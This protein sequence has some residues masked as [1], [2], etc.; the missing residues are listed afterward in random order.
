MTSKPKPKSN[1]VALPLENRD[2]Q[3]SQV[4]YLF[5]AMR[6]HHWI[7]NL[8]VFTG[9]LFAFQLSTNTFY[10]TLGAFLCFCLAASAIYLLNDVL[11][12]KA[13]QAHPVKRKRPIAAGFVSV[14]AALRMAAFCLLLSLG[15]SFWI[16]PWLG[17]VLVSYSVLQ[18]L[19]NTHLKHQVILDLMCISAGFVLRGLAGTVAA[20]VLPSSWFI[21]CVGL[22]ALYLAIEKRKAEIKTVEAPG[23][24][25]A[26]LQYYSLTWLGRME[27]IVTASSVMAYCLWTIEGAKTPWMMLTIPFVIYAIFKYQ[28]LSEQGQGEAPEETLLKSPHIFITLVLWALTSALV[29][30]V[31]K[32]LHWI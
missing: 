26:V 6:P 3:H 14:Q 15:L 24:S 10:A 29:L 1:V 28:H 23:N 27:A 20:G 12:V 22:L 19:Y 11:D 17:I 9:P 25:R 7:K 2:A 18:I 30:F 13:D 8:V 5:K 31:D 16:T 32:I 21:L 4:Y